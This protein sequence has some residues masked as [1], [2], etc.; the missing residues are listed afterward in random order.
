MD[1]LKRKRAIIK[2]QVTRIVTFA[3][4][5]GAPLSECK[6]RQTK[7]E[8][9]MQEFECLQCEI[10]ESIEDATL[11]ADETNIVQ[12]SNRFFIPLMLNYLIL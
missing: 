6:L 9:H 11:L 7:L 3:E 10:E 12:I 5:T 4:T 1:L 8:Q 2:G